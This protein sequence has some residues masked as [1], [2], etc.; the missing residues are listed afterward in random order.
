MLGEQVGIAEIRGAQ[1]V[2]GYY[3]DAVPP[4]ASPKRVHDF[5]RGRACAHGALEAIG[6]S[7]RTIPVGSCGAPVWPQG[8]VGSITHTAAYAGAVAATLDVYSALGI[9]A[10]DVDAV[11]PELWPTLFTQSELRCLAAMRADARAARAA[12]LFSAKE[13]IYKAQFPLT[14][15]WLDFLEVE[16]IV[17]TGSRFSARPAPG[18][19]SAAA[20]F[21]MRLCGRY[22]FDDTQVITSASLPAVERGGQHAQR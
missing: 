14:R 16:V 8:C 9:D 19:A 21:V 2:T 22:A 7:V 20:R 12:L 10:E 4:K 13:S 5:R 18:C 17:V 11:S 3:F 15:S 6:H 1:D